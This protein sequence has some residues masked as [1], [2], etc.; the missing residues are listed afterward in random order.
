MLDDTYAEIC[1][2][3]KPKKKLT[4]PKPPVKFKSK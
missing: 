1:F 2:N 3:Y 4:T